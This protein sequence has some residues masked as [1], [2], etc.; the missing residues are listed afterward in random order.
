MAF[1]KTPVFASEVVAYEIFPTASTLRFS[2][3]ALA[4]VV[5]RLVVRADPPG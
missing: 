3:G 2:G 1:S 5:G 4:L